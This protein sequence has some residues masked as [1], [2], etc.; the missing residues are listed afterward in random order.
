LLLDSLVAAGL[1]EVAAPGPVRDLIVDVW[2]DAVEPR[3]LE[4]AVRRSATNWPEPPSPTGEKADLSWRDRRKGHRMLSQVR[5][6]NDLALRWCF[7]RAAEVPLLAAAVCD[8]ML[9]TSVAV[10]AIAVTQ[11]RQSSPSAHPTASCT[12]PSG[13]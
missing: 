6:S 1:E 10:G 4:K 12:R 5:H 8:A 11:A 9:D 2:D 7:A 13:W 3:H